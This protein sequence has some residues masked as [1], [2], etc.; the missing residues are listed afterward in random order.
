MSPVRTA[1]LAAALALASAPAAA[2]K[3]YQWKDANGVTH[4]ADAPPASG[5]YRDRD[6]A[7]RDPALPPATQAAQAPTPAEPPGCTQARSNLEHLT[8]GATVG[9][10]ADGDGVMDGAMDAAQR[11]EQTA[12]ARNAIERFCGGDAA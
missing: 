7:G 9:F 6:L 5:E 8:S 11:E 3:V 4:Y 1:L 2:E 10:D 12:L